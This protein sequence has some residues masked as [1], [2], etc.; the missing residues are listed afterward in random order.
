MQPLAIKSSG[1]TISPAGNAFNVSTLTTAYSTRVGL[2]KPRF[3][4]RRRSGIWPPSKPGRREYPFRDFCPLLPLPAVRP[5]F[6]P[7][8]RP[9]RTLRCRDPRGGFRF[10]RFTAMVPSI[11]LSLS[12]Y[13]GFP[14]S[15]IALRVRV[16]PAASYSSTA[17]RCR[18]FKIMPRMAGESGCSTTCCIRRNPRPRMVARISLGHPMKLTTHLIL[19][20]PGFFFDVAMMRSQR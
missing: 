20:V 11:S 12:F 4:I 2:W 10:E 1:V 13:A 9:T 15:F 17:T 16:K 18:T 14:S 3:G 8:P 19:S 5:S 7:I 6:E